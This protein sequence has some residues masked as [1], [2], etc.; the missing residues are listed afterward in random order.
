[1]TYEEAQKQLSI[2]WKN[3]ATKKYVLFMYDVTKNFVHWFQSDIPGDNIEEGI[4]LD[5]YRPP[6]PP[7]G[8]HTYKIIIKEQRNNLFNIPTSDKATIDYF[9][10]LPFPIVTELTFRVSDHIGSGS[11]H[12]GSGS[13][14]IGSGSDHIGSGSDHIGSGSDHIGSGS[15]H[16]GRKADPIGKPYEKPTDQQIKYCHCVEDVETK[17]TARN[18]FAVCAHSVGTT[19]RHCKEEGF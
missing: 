1:L 8:I 18:A 15:D 6:Q 4:L 13:D 17:G 2:E 14:H 7:S 5:K 9:N 16:I 10:S 3:Q 12:I 11:D 19:Y